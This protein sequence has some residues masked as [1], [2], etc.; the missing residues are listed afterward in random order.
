MINH[1]QV[2]GIRG[3]DFRSGYYYIGDQANMFCEESL[4][5]YNK[6]KELHNSKLKIN[7]G[8]RKPFYCYCINVNKRVC[9]DSL[10]NNY[11]IL[12]GCLCIVELSSEYILNTAKFLEDNG[13]G[14]IFFLEQNFEI[15][16]DGCSLKVGD[17]SIDIGI[18]NREI[19]DTDV[20]YKRDSVLS[21]IEKAINFHN[22][23]SE[24]AHHMSMDNMYDIYDKIEADDA[25]FSSLGMKILIERDFNFKAGLYYIGDL[26]LILSED[27]YKMY[28]ERSNIYINKKVRISS[29]IFNESLSYFC[30]TD[31]GRG[32][33][34]DEN[35]NNYECVSGILGI[36][37]LKNDETIEK[38]KL[39]DKE[40]KAKIMK[41]DDNFDVFCNKGLFCFGEIEIET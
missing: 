11:D 28:I 36:I 18:T 12:S 21:K 10:E 20:K 37:E 3:K 34:K 41:Y 22:S 14:K 38:A 16:Y 40:N 23:V 30:P 17:I 19:K 6:D 29:G 7:E 9:K 31:F 32:S 33:F 13:K 8:S 2:R 27:M 26:K 1:V 35:N 5:K 15:E 39:L 25:Y 4:K 24:A